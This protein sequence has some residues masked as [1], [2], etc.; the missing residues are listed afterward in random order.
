MG[1]I[2]WEARTFLYADSILWGH[3]AYTCKYV[4]SVGG[5]LDRWRQ[6]TQIRRMSKRLI[7]VKQVQAVGAPVAGTFPRHGRL[8]NGDTRIR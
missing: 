2:P 8:W 3:D 6:R 7:G 4:W 1:P 5:E